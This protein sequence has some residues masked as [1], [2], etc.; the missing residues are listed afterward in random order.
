MLT[1]SENDISGQLALQ[2][3]EG[4]RYR[5]TALGQEVPPHAVTGLQPSQETACPLLHRHT[6]PLP[7]E[8]QIFC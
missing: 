8:V 3:I 5:I 7:P 2:Q 6:G 1:H 4:Y